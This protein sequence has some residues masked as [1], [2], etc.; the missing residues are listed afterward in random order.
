MNHRLTCAFA[1]LSLLAAC[2]TAPR[3]TAKNSC[4]VSASN[5]IGKAKG[6]YTAS[7][8]TI[9]QSCRLY[10][11][12]MMSN[13]YAEALINQSPNNALISNT[14]IIG[15]VQN[16]PQ[17]KSFQTFYAECMSKSTGTTS[18][19]PPAHLGYEKALYAIK[20]T[21]LQ[22]CPAEFVQA[23]NVFVTDYERHY[24]YIQSLGSVSLGE[25]NEISNRGLP[26]NETERTLLKNLNAQF[27]SHKNVVAITNKLRD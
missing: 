17:M 2:E 11:S 15:G 21:P 24:K 26:T 6:A 25:I 1:A 3:N 22:S 7:E 8:V 10:A 16:K 23:F 19:A 13:Y 9:E 27:E 4:M 18:Y 14:I 20:S 12:D 5:G